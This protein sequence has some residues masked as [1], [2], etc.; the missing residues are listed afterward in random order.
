MAIH[1]PS[2][3]TVVPAQTSNHST[4]GGNARAE[5][6]LRHN[7]QQRVT[8]DQILRAFNTRSFRRENP[9]SR[10]SVLATISRALNAQEP[11][12]FMMYWGKGLRPVLAKPE[13]ICL[14]YLASMFSRIKDR[15][16]PGAK[17]T[18]VFTDTH[19]QLNGHS[20]ESIETYFADLVVAAEARGFQICKLSSLMS[21][22]D[23]ESIAPQAEERPSDELLA[24]LSVSAAKWFKGN[25]TPEEGALL[26]YRA[27]MIERRVTEASFGQT[28]FVTF[29]GSAM[30]S[31]FPLNMPIFYMFSVRAGISDKPWFL[32]PDFSNRAK[33]D[34]VR[35]DTA[36]SA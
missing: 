5:L 32:P 8:A 15:Y 35:T 4:P 12:P 6:P 27:N 31:L 22:A 25:G 17:M 11:I 29:N 1:P 19:A 7:F 10:E 26:Y 14:D 3:P 20:Q 34:N 21:A 23:L 30:R 18:L 28:I 36:E 24:G 16:R 2:R 13:H 9:D 33:Q